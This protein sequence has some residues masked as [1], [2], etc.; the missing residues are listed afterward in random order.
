MATC[1]VG[2][3]GCPRHP[4]WCL[5][6]PGKGSRPGWGGAPVPCGLMPAFDADSAT[7]QQVAGSRVPPVLATAWPGEPRRGPCGDGG[8]LLFLGG[9]HT[10]THTHL[11]VRL[12]VCVCSNECL[13]YPVCL[14]VSALAC[15]A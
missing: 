4:G 7:W 11:E 2:P 9:L 5:A 8:A 10:Y 14:A 1:R 6:P 12:E 15:L 13:S 3:S